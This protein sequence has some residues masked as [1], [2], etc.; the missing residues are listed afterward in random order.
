MP[1]STRHREAFN[2]YVDLGGARSIERLRTALAARGAA[3]SVRTLYEWSRTYGWQQRLADL[4][5]ETRVAEDAARIAAE[6]EMRERQVKEALLL[7]QRGAER[8][9]A[10]ELDDVSMQAAIRALVEGAK[11]ER[12][13]RG[14][15]T[16]RGAVPPAATD[17]RLERFSDAELEQLVQLAER[18]LGGD[19]APSSG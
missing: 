6:S 18:D 1:E 5:R 10:I 13:N 3:P 16:E 12:L 4:E 7:Q 2:A 15:P 8:L 14:V 11:L 9:A 17:P 19:A